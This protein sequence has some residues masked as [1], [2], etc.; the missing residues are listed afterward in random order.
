M[1]DGYREF[2]RLQRHE[3]IS[4]GAVCLEGSG[5]II[6]FLAGLFAGGDSIDFL[7]QQYGRTREDIEAALRLIV[8][9][10]GHNLSEKR[11]LKVV[12]RHIPLLRSADT[13]RKRRRGSKGR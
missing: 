7:A 5:I 2:G 11:A 10:R 3:G 12:E 8:L 9:A 4:G 1:S 6:E 13:T